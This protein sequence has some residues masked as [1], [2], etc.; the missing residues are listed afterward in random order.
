[1]EFARIVL[2]TW[3]RG[4]NTWLMGAAF[5]PL[6][7]KHT[8]TVPNLYI[9]LIEYLSH[10]ATAFHSFRSQD[11]VETVKYSVVLQCN[12]TRGAD[13]EMHIQDIVLPV[14]GGKPC[15]DS[16]TLP[17]EAAWVCSKD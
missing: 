15:T 17:V 14:V 3:S 16:D 13:T 7:S 11:L 2:R 5:I 8:V 4:V 10:H 9:T 1:M 6:R 12:V